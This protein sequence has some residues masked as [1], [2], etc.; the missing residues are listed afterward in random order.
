M[1]HE[2]MGQSDKEQMITSC[3]NAIRE[4]IKTYTDIDTVKLTEGLML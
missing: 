2:K 1:T 4:L 3:G